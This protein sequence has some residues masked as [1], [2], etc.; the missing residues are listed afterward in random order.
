MLGI[1]IMSMHTIFYST[2]LE[3]VNVII[4]LGVIFD[5]DLSFVLHCNEKIT[6]LTQC[7]GS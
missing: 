3:N 6:K 7:W 5:P 2:K 1:L 4:D